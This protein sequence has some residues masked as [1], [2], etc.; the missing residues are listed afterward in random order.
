M[1]LSVWRTMMN[2][3]LN[4]FCAGKFCGLTP[5]PVISVSSNTAIVRFLSDRANQQQ[6]FRGNWTTDADVIPTSPSPPPNPWDNIIISKWRVSPNSQQPYISDVRRCVVIS[7]GGCQFLNGSF[8]FFPAFYG[9]NCSRIWDWILFFAIPKLWSNRPLTI[10]VPVLLT[11]QFYTFLC[12][13]FMKWLLYLY[14][15][16]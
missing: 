13:F 12:L 5:P 1:F 14:L 9:I 3:T 8:C 15:Q 7:C 11:R 10:P 4:F 2:K 6:G 16:F